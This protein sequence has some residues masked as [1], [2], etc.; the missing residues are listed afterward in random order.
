M[1]DCE[2]Q[3]PWSILQCSKLFIVFP[4]QHLLY[5]LRGKCFATDQLLTE[6]SEFIILVASHRG[7]SY[8]S[9]W[10]Q[11]IGPMSASLELLGLQAY[12]PMAR[13]KKKVNIGCHHLSYYVHV[14]LSVH[15]YL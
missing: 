8:S 12:T 14:P 3:S 10:K 9:G 13:Q 15:S 7:P 2:T 11:I 1:L 6:F 5:L 4:L